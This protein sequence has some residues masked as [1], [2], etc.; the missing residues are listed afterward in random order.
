MSFAQRTEEVGGRG[1]QL[2]KGQSMIATIRYGITKY[3]VTMEAVA[4]KWQSRIVAPGRYLT[5]EEMQA[6]AF[7]APHRKLIKTLARSLL[8]S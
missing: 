8:S 1:L 2:G 4:A 6:L 7:A 3:S 5:I